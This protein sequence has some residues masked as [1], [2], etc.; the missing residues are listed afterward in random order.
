[1]NSAVRKFLFLIIVI[2]AFSACKKENE[3]PCEDVVCLT[4]RVC[5]NGN[6]ID[7]PNYIPPCDT[8]QCEVYEI[9]QNGNCLNDPNFT[10]C[11]TITCFPGETCVS[12]NCVA[13]PNDPCFNINCPTGEICENGNCIN[14]NQN[15]LGNYEGFMD[16]DGDS[17]TY[18]VNN[19]IGID[20]RV[21]SS[22]PFIADIAQ[23]S[24]S[25]DSLLIDAVFEFDINNNV[26]NVPLTIAVGYNSNTDEFNAQKNREYTEQTSGAIQLVIKFKVVEFSGTLTSSGAFDGELILDDPS[27]SADDFID[28][29][30]YLSAL[31]Q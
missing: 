15:I 20:N 11:D 12:G 27:G 14:P 1:M 16:S 3:D 31:K 21:L 19:G 10:P 9:C 26:V 24:N 2:A 30:F 5:E 17:I 25:A 8:L 22:T 28:A 18:L 23:S 6:C 13:D 4:G 7:D 29:T